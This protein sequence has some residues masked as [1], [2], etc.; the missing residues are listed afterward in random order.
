MYGGFASNETALGQRNPETHLT[1]LS[2]D[3]GAP[4]DGSDN[5]YHVVVMDGSSGTKI[6]GNTIFDGFTIIHAH[7]DGSIPAYQATGGGLYCD[8]GGTGSQCNPTLNRLTFVENYAGWGGAIFNNGAGGVSSPTLSNVTF[9]MN[10]A[11]NYGGAMYN[12]GSA[13]GFSSPTLNNV[14]FTKTRL[15][16]AVARC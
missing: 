10:Q 16:I 4:G 2:G 11:L 13:N 3:M 15:T 7:A 8:G 12:D 5:S 14:S 9:S 1:V 6:D